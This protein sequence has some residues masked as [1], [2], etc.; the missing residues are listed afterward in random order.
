MQA[1]HDFATGLAAPSAPSRSAAGLQFDV[2]Q[3]IFRLLAPYQMGGQAL[4]PQTVI[5]KGTTV[6]SLTVMDVIMELEDRFD[7]SIP[8]NTVAGIDTIDQ[9]AQ[10]VVTL[11]ARR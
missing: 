5:S 6:D 4:T 3:E 9:L 8:I 11:H 2:M 10:T 7:V 1:T